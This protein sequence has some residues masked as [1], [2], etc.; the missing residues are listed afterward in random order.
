MREAAMGGIEKDRDFPVKGCNRVAFD[1]RPQKHVKAE[2]C[3]TPLEMSAMAIQ[4]WKLTAEA[5]GVA[6]LTILQRRIL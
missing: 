2:P 6:T 3:H 1:K 4:P 5:D